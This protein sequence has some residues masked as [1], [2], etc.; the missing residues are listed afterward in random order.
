MKRGK[1]SKVSGFRHSSPANNC[2]DLW[3][4]TKPA[5]KKEYRIGEVLM[6]AE[7]EQADSLCITMVRSCASPETNFVQSN[8]VA[9]LRVP[10]QFSTI[11]FRSGRYEEKGQE[12]VSKRVSKESYE[13]NDRSRGCCLRMSYIVVRSWANRSWRLFRSD[14]WSSFSTKRKIY[15]NVE[16][17]R[18]EERHDFVVTRLTRKY[19]SNRF[20]D[21]KL[22]R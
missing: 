3:N 8:T 21:N 4:I 7:K 19:Y 17:L 15:V 2:N 5:F 13:R 20:S 12:R 22:L 10:S 11:L 18:R 16:S 14:A 1:N 9:A 6:D